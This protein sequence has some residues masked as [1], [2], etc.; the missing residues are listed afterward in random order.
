MKLSRIRIIIALMSTALL[1]I[2]LVQVYWIKSAVEQK[3][4]VFQF[5]VAEA[6]TRTT[7]KVET[8]WI[9][10]ML[11]EQTDLFVSD[12]IFLIAQA[13][14]MSAEILSDTAL[15]G[16]FRAQE[17]VP[18]EPGMS[19]SGPFSNRPTMVLEPVEMG[20][21]MSAVPGR[22]PD[23]MIPSILKEIDK[24]FR[25]NADRLDQVMRRMMVEMM[26]QGVAPEKRVD[27]AYLEQVLGL[28]LRNKGIEANYEYGVLVNGTQLISAVSQNRKGNLMGTAHTASLYP[29]NLFFGNDL[30]LVQFPNQRNYILSSLWILLLGSVLFTSVIIFVF[31][32][33]IHVIIRQKK[34]SEIKNDFINNMTHE[35]KTPIATIS[36]ATDAISN[37]SVLS[38]PDKVRHFTGIIRD[39][40]KR[41]N[42]QVEKVLQAA[43]LDKK[44][45]NLKVDEVD[46]S[47]VIKTATDNISLMVKEK[48]GSV[49]IRQD[50]A[51]ATVSGDRVH[52][53][54]LVYNL[55]DNACKYS[56]E[57]PE[58]EVSTRNLNGQL[59]IAVKD[60]GIGMSADQQKM[61]F[62]KFYR[63]PTGN[64]HDIKGFGLGLTYVKTV[65][66]AHAGQITVRS[67]PGKGSVFTIQLPLNK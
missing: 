7:E 41:M 18:D 45:L 64:V 61:I 14:E 8:H 60:N 26:M 27:T 49:S 42:G 47:E 35:F 59:L 6:L 16:A 28:E 39:E 55:L 24:Q 21:N 13:G 9:A 37:Q 57:H 29:N 33:S 30:L 54:N 19:V 3:Q 10:T 38:D 52:L 65:V 15:A 22:N 63:V 66:E 56:G 11:K 34:L 17:T 40:N 20:I 44:E 58:I 23:G 5:Q 1:G 46:M 32:Y 67:Q 48:D 62:E 50:A 53:S 25:V 12:S 31:S 2:V 36:L 43:L 4:Q 51:N